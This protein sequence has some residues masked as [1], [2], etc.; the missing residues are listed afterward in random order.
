[1]SG[2]KTNIYNTCYCLYTL[3]FNKMLC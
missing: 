3:W 2:H 1:M